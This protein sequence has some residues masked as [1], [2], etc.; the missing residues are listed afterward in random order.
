M[1]L[2]VASGWNPL[3]TM[4]IPF[5]FL[6]SLATFDWSRGPCQ[7]SLQHGL[8]LISHEFHSCLHDIFALCGEPHTARSGH[9]F[10]LLWHGKACVQL[11]LVTKL[12]GCFTFGQMRRLSQGTSSLGEPAGFC[13]PSWF[14]CGPCWPSWSSCGHWWPS[15]SSWLCWQN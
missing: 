9:E 12:A 2:E 11:L 5:C 6:Q 10:P 3:L 4:E 15:W 7:G 1:I 14:C 8:L 13:W